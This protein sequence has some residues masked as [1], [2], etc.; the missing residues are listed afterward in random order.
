MSCH[1]F[2]KDNSPPN[3]RVA[4]PGLLMFLA[5]FRA[6]IELG[7]TLWLN[8]KKT[9]FGGNFWKK[10][11]GRFW[12]YSF[13]TF[14]WPCWAVFPFKVSSPSLKPILVFATPELQFRPKRVM[15]RQGI[16]SPKNWTFFYFHQ[17]IQNW[18]GPYQWTPKEV[19]RA[20]RYS[21]LGVRSVGAVGISWNQGN[22]KL[23]CHSLKLPPVSGAWIPRHGR[24]SKWRPGAVGKVEMLTFIWLKKTHGRS[25]E[26][27]SLNLLSS[28]KRPRDHK[29]HSLKLSLKKWWW[30]GDVLGRPNL[31]GWT[32][33]WL[34]GRNF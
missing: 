19:A 9:R 27:H 15:P 13:L 7:S 25:W 18:M 14:F 2:F 6:V 34:L 1:S 5:G 22:S 26:A 12:N 33:S 3:L 29:L 28:K 32:V 11:D 17:S 21:G 8:P 10:D 23:F 30:P 24:D 20:I 31:Q 4:L 16:A